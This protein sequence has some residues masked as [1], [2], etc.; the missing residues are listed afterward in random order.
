[1]SEARKVAILRSS[2][3]TEGYRIWTE[4]CVPRTSYA[5]RV[6]HLKNRF[7]P[8]QSTNYALAQFNRRIK[9]SNETCVEDVTALRALA[10]K[11]NYPD[12]I[13]DDLV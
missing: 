13:F 4:L 12:E 8:K 2:L 6:E 1:M 3:D 11:C 9:S 7:A 5:D 10:R